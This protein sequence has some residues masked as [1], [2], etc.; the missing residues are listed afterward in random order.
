MDKIDY[1][2]GI[3]SSG[4]AI[5]PSAVAGGRIEIKNH[6]LLFISPKGK[7][8]EKMDTYDLSN[9]CISDNKKRVVATKDI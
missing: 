8:L 7:V 1:S 9:T 5:K 6:K 3:A 4:L 2:T